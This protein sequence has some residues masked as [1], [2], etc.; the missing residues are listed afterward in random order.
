MIADFAQVALMDGT[1][2]AAID[3]G[4]GRE[5]LTLRN[6]KPAP[7]PVMERTIENHSDVVCL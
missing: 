2:K 4:P 7:T 6:K 3:L 1:T 5:L